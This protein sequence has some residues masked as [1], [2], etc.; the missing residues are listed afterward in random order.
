[1]RSLFEVP[2]RGGL[3][4]GVTGL[5]AGQSRVAVAL[6]QVRPEV[7]QC[8]GLA[9]GGERGHLGVLAALQQRGGG[10]VTG[11]AQGFDLGR[12]VHRA[13]ELLAR[14]TD[15]HRTTPHDG[16]LTDGDFQRVAC[17]LQVVGQ[18]GLGVLSA[19]AVLVAQELHQRGQLLARDFLHDLA[20]EDR[21][22]L[23]GWDARCQALQNLDLFTKPEALTQH[24]GAC[25]DASTGGSGSTVKAC[26][27][28]LAVLLRGRLAEQSG[29]RRPSTKPHDQRRRGLHDAVGD[30]EH[31]LIVA[32]LGLQRCRDLAP[33][34]SRARGH[35]GH[36]IGANEIGGGLDGARQHLAQTGEAGHNTTRGRV[37]DRIPDVHA[38]SGGSRYRCRDG[39]TAADGHVVNGAAC[40]AGFAEAP[41]LL[42]LQL[43]AFQ[44][45][46]LLGRWCRGVGHQLV[47]VVFPCGA[48]RG[49]CL[50]GFLR[51]VVGQARIA[52]SSTGRRWRHASGQ[53]LLCCW[54]VRKPKIPARFGGD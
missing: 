27:A 50:R 13:G 20:R 53:V 15:R 9:L 18:R 16:R 48:H 43:N 47:G 12:A 23:F 17:L 4:H 14:L 37:L 31:Q 5:C 46:D 32:G 30:V 26:G 44:N 2:A 35:I 22:Q 19:R 41:R 6:L 29:H 34:A 8:L 54:L 51:A 25:H 42:G 1:M 10:F 40:L 21:C 45:A 39:F 3:H 33:G 49:G 28:P 36:T 7:C 38:D 52:A 11:L 24:L